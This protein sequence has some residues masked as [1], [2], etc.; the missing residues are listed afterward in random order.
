MTSLYSESTEAAMADDHDSSNEPFDD[1]SAINSSQ[2]NLLEVVGESGQFDGV[3]GTPTNEL[4]TCVFATGKL[5][6]SL[7]KASG[8]WMI[9]RRGYKL[10][11]MM[12]VLLNALAVITETLILAICG[13]LGEKCVSIDVKNATNSDHININ[14]TAFRKFL[15]IAE[16]MYIWNGL[17]STLTLVLLIYSL[18][19]LQKTFPSMTFDV[20]ESS[21]SRK[22][23]L[24]VN[25]MLVI[26]VIGSISAI[27]YPVSL[28]AHDRKLE[29]YLCFGFAIFINYCTGIFC[30][31]VFAIVS[32]AMNNLVTECSSNIVKA[33]DGDLNTIIALHQQLRD[34]LII[35]S[36]FFKIWFLVHWIMF[37]ANCLSFLAFY[38]IQYSIMLNSKTVEYEVFILVST[39]II[40]VIPCVFA[41]RVT[42]KCKELVHHLNNKKQQNWAGH[43]F[44]DRGALNNFIFYA[45]RSNCGFRVGNFTFDTKGTWISVLLG[46]TGL[47]LK[48]L[49]FSKDMSLS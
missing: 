19:K 29:T 1:T 30:C 13:P 46:V 47:I 31:S 48:L 24:F 7:A 21:V 6:R 34:K 11:S 41:S 5:F 32:F 44:S 16:A 35:I 10:L 25:S 20:V 28:H 26:Y 39:L 2:T 36:G 8:L 43:P 18:L 49:V 40:F 23:W 3:I 9:H 45:E 37:G 42:W 12:F 33:V 27:G 17:A 4:P 38:S 15:T 22:E 14:V